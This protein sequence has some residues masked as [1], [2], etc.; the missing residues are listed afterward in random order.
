VMDQPSLDATDAQPAHG[1][2]DEKGVLD[3]GRER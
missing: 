1:R 3:D 2:N